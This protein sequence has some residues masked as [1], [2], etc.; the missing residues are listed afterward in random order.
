MTAATTFAPT[1]RLHCHEQ[2]R[3]LMVKERRSPPHGRRALKAWSMQVAKRR[4][5]CRA[6]VA[7]ARKL[8]VALHRMWATGRDF[9]WTAGTH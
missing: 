8:A 1:A 4:G 5:L 9:H 3:M 6:T 7:V 2:R